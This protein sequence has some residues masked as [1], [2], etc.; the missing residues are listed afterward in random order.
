MPRIVGVH[1]IGQQFKGPNSLHGEWLDAL[2]DGVELA[3]GSPPEAKDLVCAFYGKLFRPS[4]TKSADL[5]PYDAA[6]VTDPFEQEL[7]AAWWLDAA[8]VEPGQ[9]IGPGESTKGRTPQLVQRALDALSRSRFFA[10]IAER[11]FI[12]DLKQ[13]H[14]YFHDDAIRRSACKRVERVVGDDT[15]VIVGHSLGSVVAYEC[16]CAHPEWPVTTLVTLGSPLGIANLVFDRL[17]P[18]PENGL[19]AWPGGIRRW[20]NIADKGDVVALVKDLGPRF[21]LG[22]GNVLIY[23]GASAHAVRPYLSALETGRV[24]AAALD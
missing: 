4:G 13:V 24:I 20:V 14:A 10:G 17:R 3:G 21:G 16:L 18:P 15:R 2:R 19:G 8:R 12:N 23:N 7:L 22:V 6:D 1:G 5:P 9:V 11:A